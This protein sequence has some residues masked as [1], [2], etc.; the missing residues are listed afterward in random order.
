MMKKLMTSILPNWLK[1]YSIWLEMHSNSTKIIVQ[2]V[3]DDLYK[4]KFNQNE[5]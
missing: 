1:F 5:R 3:A 4:I 2:N